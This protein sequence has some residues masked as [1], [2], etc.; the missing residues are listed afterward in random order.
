MLFLLQKTYKNIFSHSIFKQVTSVILFRSED[1]IKKKKYILK[2]KFLNV[3]LYSS[4]KLN[5]FKT[6]SFSFTHLFSSETCFLYMANVSGLFK[7]KQICF[8]KTGRTAT[9]SNSHFVYGV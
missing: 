6:C 5:D 3:Y 9:I 1:D 4:D 2:F 7:I 8:V